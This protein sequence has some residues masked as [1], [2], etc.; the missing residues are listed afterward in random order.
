M[1]TPALLHGNLSQ[2]GI[3]CTAY[4]GAGQ[5]GQGADVV[6]ELFG[7]LQ[8]GGQVYSAGAELVA[9]L[10]HVGVVEGL[11][12][13]RQGVTVMGVSHLQG[14]PEPCSALVCS[15]RLLHLTLPL[16]KHALLASW[17]ISAYEGQLVAHPSHSVD[18]TAQER[19]APWSQTR[20]VCWSDA[21]QLLLLAW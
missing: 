3:P 11:E 8:V 6:Q 19:P 18:H 14:P 12:D 5:Q 1:P 20:Q 16:G 21:W 15:S 9:P 4:L 17:H 13:G 10:Q 7:S 2:P